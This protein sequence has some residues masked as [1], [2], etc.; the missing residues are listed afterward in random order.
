MLVS[1]PVPRL[2]LGGIEQ[3][4]VLLLG[5]VYPRQHL[6][7]MVT[8]TARVNWD[9]Q[10]YRCSEQDALGQ[11]KAI[12]LEAQSWSPPC[13]HQVW[14][15]WGSSYRTSMFIPAH[16]AKYN[17]WDRCSKTG[18]FLSPRATKEEAK[19]SSEA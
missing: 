3:T 5:D 8:P 6:W 2:P 13:P 7:M 14:R 19:G 12:I 15:E 11:S 17:Q 1:V 4:P 10:R 18:S 16:G 9:P